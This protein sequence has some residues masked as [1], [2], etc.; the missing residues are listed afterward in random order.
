VAWGWVELQ[1]VSL[2]W[3]LYILGGNQTQAPFYGHFC[4][5][6]PK[7]RVHEVWVGFFMMTPVFEIRIRIR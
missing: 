2:K 3:D 1:G 4:G 6:L 5:D 7:I